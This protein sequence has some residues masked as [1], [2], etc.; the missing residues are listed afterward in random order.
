TP[1]TAST[2]ETKPPSAKEAAALISNLPPADRVQ[3]VVNPKNAAPYAGKTGTVRGIVRATGDP[4]PALPQVLAKMDANCTTS[5]V[6]FGMLFREGP[7]RE[8][9]DVLVAVTGYDGFVPATGT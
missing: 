8:L 3:K 2:T 7:E 6:T 5:R 9:A 4:A 1:G